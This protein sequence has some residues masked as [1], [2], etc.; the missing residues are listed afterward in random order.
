VKFL[1]WKKRVRKGPK[2]T[3]SRTRKM[4]GLGGGRGEGG[5]LRD[6]LEGKGKSSNFAEPGRRQLQKTQVSRSEA[7]KTGG[8]LRG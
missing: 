1:P 5:S 3:C 7:R 8:K 2:R 6:R 4:L